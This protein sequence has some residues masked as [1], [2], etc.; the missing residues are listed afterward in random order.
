MGMDLAPAVTYIDRTGTRVS[1]ESAYL[2]PAA[3]AR[4]N[5]VVA[6][7]AR[8]TRVLFGNALGEEST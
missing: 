2:T 1:T 3:L 8:V 7:H 4:P 6:T 5:L